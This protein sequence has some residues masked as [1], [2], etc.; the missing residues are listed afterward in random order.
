MTSF[1]DSLFS[2]FRLLHIIAGFMAL[3]VCWIPM[4]TRK[5]GKTHVRFGWV[6][7]AAMAAVAVS[8]WYMGIWR[9]TLDAF[10][11]EETVAFAWFLIFI[12]LLSSASAWYGIR[13]LR[14][15]QRK[16]AHRGV[17]DI[18]IPLALVLFGIGVVHT[19]GAFT[20]YC[21]NGFRW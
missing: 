18:V 17:L 21:C 6:Y 5:G 13:V 11:T 19:A 4:L 15:K 12:A 7:V 1:A 10:S 20:L 16:S 9:I 14:Y 2:L 3:V 8:A